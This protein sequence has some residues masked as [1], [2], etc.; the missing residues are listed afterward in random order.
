PMTEAELRA[1]VA[2]RP[3]TFARLALLPAWEA[4]GEALVAH[5][6]SRARDALHE[7]K[8][9]GDPYDQARYLDAAL[10]PLDVPLT[11]AETEALREGLRSYDDYHAFMTTLRY[12]RSARVVPAALVYYAALIARLG[13]NAYLLYH[14]GDFRALA[15]DRDGARAE[16]E[17]AKRMLPAD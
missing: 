1:I 14:R 16:Y 13:A 7:A 11:T 5:D 15:G 4:V 10:R 17:A 8:S 2:A 3:E 6:L 12:E 9:A